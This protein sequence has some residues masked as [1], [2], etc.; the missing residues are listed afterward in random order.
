MIKR[1]VCRVVGH[2]DE[3]L[4]QGRAGDNFVKCLRCGRELNVSREYRPPPRGM[5]F[6]SPHV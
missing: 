6:G 3:P 2:K 4:E 1:W 5:D